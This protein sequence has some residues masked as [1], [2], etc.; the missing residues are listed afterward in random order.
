[1]F[2][3]L[4]AG[5]N[6]AR[7]SVLI[8]LGIAL[9]LGVADDV[10]DLSVRWRLAGEVIVGVA[11]AVVIPSRGPVGS[12]VTVAFVLVLLNAV[13]LLDGLDGL[14]SGVAA[15][16]ALGF[17][18]AF[19]FDGAWSAVALA[20][21]GALLGFLVWNRP[22]AR[23]YLGD[24]GSYLVGTALAVLLAGAWRPEEPVALGVGS[25]LFVAVPIADMTIAIVRRARAR[26]P[27]LQGDR[28][29]VY[30]QLVDRGW[31][32]LR[33]TLGCIAAQA[34]LVAVGIGIVHMPAPVAI[35]TTS[36]VVAVVAAF[37]LRAFTPPASWMS[38]DE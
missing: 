11:A 12:L 21:A 4:A 3:A 1:V 34:V 27:L 26:R 38:S 14:A 37:A 24:A 8:P 16:A 2:I 13:N 22:P 19:S 9:A 33:A 25:L 28:G 29:H 10:V 15:V 36:L 5:V 20:L 31:S 35:A 17:A 18:C 7:A 6:A 23:I 32:P 30:D